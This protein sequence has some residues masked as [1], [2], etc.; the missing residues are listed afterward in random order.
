MIP[1][2][3]YG[4]IGS[5]LPMIVLFFSSDDSLPNCLCH[6]DKRKNKCLKRVKN[7]NIYCLLFLLLDWLL[8]LI[9]KVT[10]ITLFH[11]KRLCVIN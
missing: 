1:T 5:T 10:P 3:L 9:L 7:A 11:L 4:I 6:N 8:Q 2:K